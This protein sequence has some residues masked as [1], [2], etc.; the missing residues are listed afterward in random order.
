VVNLKFGRTDAI[1]L[2]DTVRRSSRSPARLCA[3]L[4]VRH[5]FHDRE[6]FT[7]VGEV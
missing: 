5:L 3:R 6:E 7:L 4:T 2:L 1:A